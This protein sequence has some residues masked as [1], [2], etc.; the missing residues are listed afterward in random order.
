[1]I[2][3]LGWGVVIRYLLHR[4]SLKDALRHISDRMGLRV[5]VVILPFPEAAVDVDSVSDW[6]FAHAIASRGEL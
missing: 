3:Q 4:L 6:H 5:A 2:G 1:M